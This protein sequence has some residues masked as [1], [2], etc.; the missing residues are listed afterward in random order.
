MGLIGRGQVGICHGSQGTGMVG[1]CRLEDGSGLPCAGCTL[2]LL[3]GSLVQ[4][5]QCR[6]WTPPRRD[7]EVVG[8]HRGCRWG[9]CRHIARGRPVPG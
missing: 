6:A 2:N 3:T 5:T 9:R 8:T 7:P 4:P 1:S